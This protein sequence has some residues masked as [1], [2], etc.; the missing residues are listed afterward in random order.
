MVLTDQRRIKKE[1]K[2]PINRDKHTT[3]TL[4]RQESS[5]PQRPSGRQ[6]AR[7]LSAERS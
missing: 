1:F 7:G 2:E 4:G 6:A 5:V 3:S